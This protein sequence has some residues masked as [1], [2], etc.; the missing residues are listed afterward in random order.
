MRSSICIKIIHARGPITAGGNLVGQDEPPLLENWH[1][2][3][4]AAFPQG[5]GLSEAFS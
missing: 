3:A 5:A 2:E 4:A 1:A